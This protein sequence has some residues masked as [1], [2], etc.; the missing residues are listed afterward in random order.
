MSFLYKLLQD[1]YVSGGHTIIPDT[2][3]CKLDGEKA[4][5]LLHQAGIKGRLKDDTQP[6]SDGD[7][8]YLLGRVTDGLITLGI[9]QQTLCGLSLC[10]HFKTRD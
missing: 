5:S 2:T 4:L 1:S 9:D 8:G 10:R 7:N 3:P 6:L